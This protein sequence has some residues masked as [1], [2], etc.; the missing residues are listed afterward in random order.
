MRERLSG[1]GRYPAL[2][3][4]VETPRDEEA[5]ARLVSRG[6]LIARGGGRAY[7]DSALN[8]GLTVSMRR[9][10]RF[11]DFDPATGFL[12][13]EAGV[14]LA[15]IIAA[16][17]PRGWF[18]TV[19]PGTKHATLGGLIAADVH[20]KNHHVAGSFGAHV[21]WLDLMTAE[22]QVLRASPEENAGLFAATVGG[23]GLTGVI[24]RASVRLVPV[25]SAWIRQETVAAP[26]LDAAMEAFEA[27]AAWPY[28]VA[29]IDCLARGPSLGRSIVHRGAHARLADL[30]AGR[31][32]Y[33][34]RVPGRTRATVPLDLPSWALNGTAM[35]AFNAAYYARGAR[36]AGTSLVDWDRFFYPLDAIGDW[37]RVYGARGFVQFQCVI[38][39][40]RARAGLAAL[41]RAVS[42]SGRG[43]F[44]AVLKQFGAQ[45]SAFSFPRAGWTLA[46][47]FPATPGALGLVDRLDRIALDHG[48]RFYLA[49]DARMRRETFAASEP[50][51]EAFTALRRETGADRRFRSLQSE[52]L[53]L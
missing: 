6:S 24:L 52:R 31:L 13:A 28:S 18:P 9:F 34:F 26:D 17:L 4:R 3:C 32:A 7:G 10:S 47:D 42:E 30:D 21:G 46:L 51:A 29:W 22:G 19:T 53:G 36:S 25:E 2:D 33:P 1:W 41:L 12:T 27:S 20:G 44:L 37:N 40:E 43:S 23:M 8:P 15:E 39:E 5:L 35:R 48:G 49:K 50:R 45:E 16:F 11:V 14:S 38:P